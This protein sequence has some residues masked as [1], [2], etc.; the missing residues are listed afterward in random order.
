MREIYYLSG[1]YRLKILW[2]IFNAI[3]PRKCFL[4][5]RTNAVCVSYI[6]IAFVLS[7]YF[8]QATC[9]LCRQNTY[10]PKEV[11]K[12]EIL[13]FTGERGESEIAKG[14]NLWGLTG[15]LNKRIHTVFPLCF[16]IQVT[17]KEIIFPQQNFVFNMNNEYLLVLQIV[18]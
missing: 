2:E 17:L 14:E 8:H 7:R 3:C 11:R 15:N 12:Y 6:H 4:T 13:L 10:K 16:S 18:I 5:P 1:F 9:P